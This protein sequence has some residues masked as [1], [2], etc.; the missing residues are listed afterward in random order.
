MPLHLRVATTLCAFGVV[1][2]A[3]SVLM[4]QKPAAA[5]GSAMAVSAGGVLT[6][7]RVVKVGMLGFG[8]RCVVSSARDARLALT[9]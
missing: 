6:C 1:G 4:P 3:I 5:P 7:R 8:A 2:G 9:D